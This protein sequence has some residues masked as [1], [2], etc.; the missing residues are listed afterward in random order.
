MSMSNSDEKLNDMLLKLEV[1]APSQNLNSRIIAKIDIV[2]T[3]DSVPIL[4]Q[5]LNSFIIPKPTYALAFS[6]AFGLALG[7]PDFNMLITNQSNYES[8]EALSSLILGE[9]DLYE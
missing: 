6:L 8:Y 1:P 7:F 9:V 2:P 5:V 4:Q 3:D